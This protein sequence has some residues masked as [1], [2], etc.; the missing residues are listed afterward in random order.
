MPRD[1]KFSSCCQMVTITWLANTNTLAT[2]KKSRKQGSN[3]AQGQNGHT[4]GSPPLC[5]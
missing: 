2:N 1:A 3:S 5:L 4:Q